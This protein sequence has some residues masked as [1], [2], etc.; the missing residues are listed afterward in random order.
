[1]LRAFVLLLALSFCPALFAQTQVPAPPPQ[2]AREALIEMITGGQQGMMKH[3]TVEMQKNMEAGKSNNSMPDLSMFEQMKSSSS[4]FQTFESGSVLLATSDPK[5]NTKFEVHIDSDDLSG[6]ADTI[7]I[8]FHQFHE[9]IEKNIPYNLLL[10]QFSIGLKRQE[11]IWRLNDISINIKLPLGDP[12][13]MEKIEKGMSSGGMFAVT[14]GGDGH[15]TLPTPSDMPLENVVPLV[16]FAESS[17]ASGHPEVGFTCSLTDLAESN[18]FN[19]DPRIFNGQP[20]L[21]YKFALSGCQGKPAETFHLTAEPAPFVPGAKAFCTDATHNIRSSEDGRGST[22]LVSGKAMHAGEVGS[23]SISS[24][25][26]KAP[27]K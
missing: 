5:S 11:N 3:L 6:D 2:T 4:N 23:L 13:L 14:A 22:C 9:G 21:G 1:M 7:E 17:F 25:T 15:T 12:K 26:K 16:A 20:Y 24:G 8:S 10:S 19:L 18:H 27:Q